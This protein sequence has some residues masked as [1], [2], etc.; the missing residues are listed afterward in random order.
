M[1]V[2]NILVAYFHTHTYIYILA[3]N[4]DDLPAIQLNIQKA[5]QHWGQVSHLLARD[6]ASTHIMGYFYKAVIQAVLLY[7]A[8]TWVPSQHMH[9]LLAF[10][11]HCCVCHIAREPICQLPGGTWVTP[12]SSLV[13]EKCGL[14]TI[15]HYIKCLKDTM[16]IFV[17][18]RPIYDIGKNSA[19]M[20]INTNQLVWW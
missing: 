11:H 18:Q 13:L 1:V 15:D 12:H 4:D 17:T 19:P 2:L 9:Q 8:K 10:F 14:F 16:Q 7:G 5:C 6:S 3:A 20:A